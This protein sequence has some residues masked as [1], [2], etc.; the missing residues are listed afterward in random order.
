MV[1]RVILTDIMNVG[2]VQTIFIAE[3]GTINCD[4]DNHTAFQS[5]SVIFVVVVVLEIM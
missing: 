1:F 3:K 2:I 4:C 5:F